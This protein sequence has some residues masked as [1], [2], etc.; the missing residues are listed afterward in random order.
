VRGGIL[1]LP[2]DWVVNQYGGTE[3]F[4]GWLAMQPRFHRMEIADLDPSELAAL[5]PNIKRLDALLT[6]YWLEHFSDD[7]LRRVHVVYFFESVFDEPPTKFHLHIHL[8]PRTEQ[9]GPSLEEY[10]TR[11]TTPGSAAG[12]NAWRIP[13]ITGSALFP[14]RYRWTDSNVDALMTWLR[15][16]LEAA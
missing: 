3:G 16:K 2:G 10:P 14:E 15:A 6:R 12:I 1:T 5:G 4:L 9:V 11:S 13:K 7:P 8:I